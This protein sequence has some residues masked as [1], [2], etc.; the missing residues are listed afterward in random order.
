MG[1]LYGWFAEKLWS[2]ISS[3]VG[4]AIRYA[5]F[6]MEMRGRLKPIDRYPSYDVN[7]G[8]HKPLHEM[9]KGWTPAQ[10]PFEQFKYGIGI[11]GEI[12]PFY[13]AIP[14]QSCPDPLEE[15]L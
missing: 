6:H 3:R 8:I 15:L 14:I 13:P 9:Y 5:E 12:L 2:L 4:G 11:N 10:L 7:D 1:R